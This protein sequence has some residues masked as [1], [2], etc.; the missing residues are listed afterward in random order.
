MGNGRKS[1][2]PVNRYALPQDCL[3]GR[4][5]RSL[6]LNKYHLLS[7]AVSGKLRLVGNR[8]FEATEHNEAFLKDLPC[9]APGVFSYSE[10]LGHENEPYQIELD[11]HFYAYA[12]NCWFNLKI[13]LGILRY[14]LSSEDRIP[15]QRGVFE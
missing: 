4:L 6:T 11:E 14:N 12:I 13:L 8:L 2:M 15:Q 5:F 7:Y 1:T 9:Y 10:Y 3:A